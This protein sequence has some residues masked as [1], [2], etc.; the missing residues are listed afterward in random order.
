[1]QNKNRVQPE[2]TGFVFHTP[3]SH[4]ENLP[5]TTKPF[6]PTTFK[7]ETL[8]RHLNDQIIV[9]DDSD[10]E[11]IGYEG[12][13]PSFHKSIDTPLST[14]HKTTHTPLQISSPTTLPSPDQTL[15]EKVLVISDDESDSLPSIHPEAPC[16]ICN[17]DTNPHHLVVCEGCNQ[18][19]HL[20][21]MTPPL[22]SIPEGDY[23]C[24]SCIFLNKDSIQNNIDITTDKNVLDYLKD[25]SLFT[26]PIEDNIMRIKKRAKNYSI[27]N[28]QLYKKENNNFGDRLVPLESQRMKII[29][30]AHEKSGI[31]ALKE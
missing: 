27:R 20:H 1:M 12:L 31:S 5:S 16:V 19:T 6:F 3:P 9:L 7:N 26:C 18:L 8:P 2:D 11:R 10:D 21:C 28:G 13:T 15:P 24:P 23:F 25:L 4:L 22:E 29:Q 17:T 14:L 30:E